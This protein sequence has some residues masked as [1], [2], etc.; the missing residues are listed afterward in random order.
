MTDNAQQPAAGNQQNAGAANNQADS[1]TADN[2]KTKVANLFSPQVEA[3]KDPLS[4]L[5]EIVQAD[6]DDYYKQ[7]LI[8]IHQ[9]RFKNR[10]KMA[11]ISLV[12]LIVLF[13]FLLIG[14]WSDGMYLCNPDEDLCRK[15]ILEVIKENDSIVI[16]IAGFFTSIV[17]AYYGVSALRPSS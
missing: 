2:Q 1:Q 10:R 5:L 12:C 11:Y 15:G 8:H 9:N 4:K 14:I 13:L 3:A 17:G 16:W 7:Q 6:I